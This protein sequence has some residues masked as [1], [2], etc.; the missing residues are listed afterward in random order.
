VTTAGR[1][2]VFWRRLA[3]LW[4]RL[5]ELRWRLAELR[6]RPPGWWRTVRV[7]LALDK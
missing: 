5:A 4:W 6:W 2:R 3:E 7:V 1:A